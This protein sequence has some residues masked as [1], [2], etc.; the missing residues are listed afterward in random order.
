MYKF[1]LIITLVSIVIHA[2]LTEDVLPVSADTGTR[3]IPDPDR[4]AQDR[5]K[6]LRLFATDTLDEQDDSLSFPLTLDGAVEKLIMHNK[7]VKKGRFE[8]LVEEQRFHAAF[9]TFEPYFSGSHEYSEAQRP[10][11]ALIEFRETLKGGI[12]GVLPSA[13]RYNVSI[14]QS[15]V[16]F[17]R[18]TL[19]WPTLNSSV[20]VSQPLLKNFIGNHPRADLKIAGSERQIAYNRYRSTL[21]GQCYALENTYWKLV[22]LQEKHRNA[23]K[24]VAV[25][26][27]IVQDSRTLVASGTISQLD[28]VEVS[29]QLAQRQ[30]TLSQVKLEHSGVVSELMQMIGYSADS[31][32]LTPTAVTP[33]LMIPMEQIPDSISLKIVDSLLSVTN[34]PELLIAEHTKTRSHLTVLQMIGKALPELNVTYAIGISGS[35]K[36]SE[37]AVEK[38]LDPDENKHNW[39]CGVEL[40]VPLGGGI[41]DRNLLKAEKL[42]RKIAEQDAV[43]LKN[44]LSVQ[45][46]LTAD[47]IRDLTHNLS[48]AAVVV[49]YRTSLLKSELVRL[50]AGLSNVRKIFELEQELA[51]ARQSELEMRAQFHMSLSLYDRLLGVTLRK[52]GLETIENGKPVLIKELVKE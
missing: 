39:A 48:N 15:N 20:T 36:N 24:S 3:F 45:S 38:F 51:N 34:Q 27:Q 37:Y 44:E 1:F 2:E 22:Y 50:R 43:Y 29:S 12:E 19:D 23:E 4:I 28:A 26:N 11:A 5:I 40:K 6:K 41:R 10:D 33:L 8:Y 31:A 7:E 21:M 32:L 9:G 25:A 13:T 17:A 35:N 14:A 16:R 47:R 52:R 18:N 30:M 42:N 49:D 46:V